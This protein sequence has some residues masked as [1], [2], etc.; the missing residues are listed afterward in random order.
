VAEDSPPP[1]RDRLEV[2]S[3]RLA[4]LLEEMSHTAPAPPPPPASAPPA[5][6]PRPRPA[7]A[8]A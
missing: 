1:P 3:A 7:A 4:R 5:P 8:S 6:Q 2:R